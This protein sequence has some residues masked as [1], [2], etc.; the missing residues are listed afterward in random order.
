MYELFDAEYW[1]AL[2]YMGTLARNGLDRQTY[3]ED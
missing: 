3:L 2:T 1:K